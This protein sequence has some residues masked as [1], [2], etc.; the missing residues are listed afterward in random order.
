MNAFGEC[1]GIGIVACADNDAGMSPLSLT[2]EADEIETIQ[3][4]DSP[5]LFVGKSQ[6]LIVWYL[7]IRP[8]C[9]IGSQNIMAKTPEFLDD[10]LWKVSVGIERGHQAS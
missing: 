10:S 9:F 3:S 4:E 2:M 6:N 5:L 1:V 7:L 8:S